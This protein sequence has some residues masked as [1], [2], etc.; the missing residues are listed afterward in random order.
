LQTVGCVPTVIGGKQICH[1]T[2]CVAEPV[3]V[4][5]NCCEPFSS[6]VDGDGET[7]MPTGV[8]FEPH[9]IIVINT[10]AAAMAAIRVP[11]IRLP[12]EMTSLRNSFRLLA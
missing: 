1:V 7:T 3:T 12:I 11:K 5:L 8:V 4:A 6:T 10:P 9:P 2:A